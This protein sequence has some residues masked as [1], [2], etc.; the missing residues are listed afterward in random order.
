MCWHGW[1]KYNAC[2]CIQGT[3]NVYLNLIIQYIEGTKPI[4]RVDLKNMLI[5]DKVTFDMS[6]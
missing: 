4:Q 2:I 1:S 3:Q 5:L 6:S